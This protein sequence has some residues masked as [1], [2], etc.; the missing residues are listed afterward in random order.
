MSAGASIVNGSNWNRERPT[1]VQW[2]EWIVLFLVTNRGRLTVTRE[3]HCCVGQ[4]VEMGDDPAGEGREVSVRKVGA[5]NS[6]MKQY[7]ASENQYRLSCKPEDH[8]PLR[9]PWNLGNLGPKGT[10]NQRLPPTQ[11]GVCRRAGH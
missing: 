10:H 1:S 11:Q 4:G 8:M 5:A 9:M 6:L 3:D 2:D 7:I